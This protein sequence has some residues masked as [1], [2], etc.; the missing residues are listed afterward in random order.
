MDYSL[1]QSAS[2]LVLPDIFILG[3]YGS[4]F[5]SRGCNDNLIRGISGKCLG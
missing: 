4:I 3:Q 1:P 2:I 5:L